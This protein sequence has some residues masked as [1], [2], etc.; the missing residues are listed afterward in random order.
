MTCSLKVELSVSNFTRHID[1]LLAFTGQLWPH[2]Q[3]AWVFA[4]KLIMAAT[5]GL[6]NA[7]LETSESTTLQRHHSCTVV[8]RGAGNLRYVR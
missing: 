1:L 2:N 3:Q 8:P 4:C 7:N 5:R 6:E